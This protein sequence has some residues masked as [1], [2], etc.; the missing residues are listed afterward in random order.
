[1]RP[2]SPCLIIFTSSFISGILAYAG[3]NRRN[4]HLLLK[5]IIKM[6]SAGILVSLALVHIVNESVL[7]LAKVTEYPLAGVCI[8]HGILINIIIFGACCQNDN[9]ICDC[10]PVSEQG[11]HR[12]RCI[13]LMM[14][15]VGCVF[16]SLFI[17]I[18]LGLAL[19]VNIVIAVA[20]HQVF[21]AVCLGFAIGDANLSFVKAIIMVMVYSAMTPLGVVIGYFV[22]DDSNIVCIYVAGCFQAF[23]AGILIYVSL[24]QIIYKECFENKTDS[25]LIKMGLIAA[26]LLGVLVMCVLALTE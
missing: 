12:V 24:F 4:N 5:R 16:H 7:T 6:F 14:F 21:E 8:L 17:G 23:S 3:Y 15:E 10:L 9:N 22:Y 19:E 1:M 18:A 2:F 11:E 26:M 25:T 20:F 13:S